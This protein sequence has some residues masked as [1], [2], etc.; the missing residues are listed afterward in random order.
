MKLFIFGKEASHIRAETRADERSICESHYLAEQLNQRKQY[1]L[2]KE[3]IRKQHVKELQEQ[4]DNLIK[5]YETEI[6]KLKDELTKKDI[7]LR[8]SQEAW[9]LFK[10]VIPEIKNY[11]SVLEVKAEANMHA[12]ARDLQIAREV[13]DNLE[14][15]QRKMHS[16]SPNVEKLLSLDEVPLMID[17]KKR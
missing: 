10:G 17:N 14:Q 11:S 9:K 5:H 3:A 13:D 6:R 15:I 8:N 2:D 7:Q 4:E 12:R 1:A 16:I